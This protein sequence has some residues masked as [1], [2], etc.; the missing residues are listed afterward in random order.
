M[1]K[2]RPLSNETAINSWKRPFKNAGILLLG[3]GTQAILSLVYLALA[4]RSLGTI[5]FG[6]LA[7]IHGT[8]I[9]AAQFLRFQSWQA[10]MRF[11][12][13]ANEKKDLG[14]FQDIVSFSV[15]LDIISAAAGVIIIIALVTP[16]SE[17]STYD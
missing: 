14:R 13:E 8:A 6:I 1:K 5:Q 2:D 16:L 17:H 10:I 12:A 7:L 11:G 15:W 9:T 4:A 3:R